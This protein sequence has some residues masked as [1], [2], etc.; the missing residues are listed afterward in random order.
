MRILR[1][2]S[3]LASTTYKCYECGWSSSCHWPTRLGVKR[4]PIPRPAWSMDRITPPAHSR[5]IPSSAS[6]ALAWRDPARGDGRRYPQQHPADGTQRH[7]RLRDEL[8]GAATVCLGWP[9][10]FPGARQPTRRGCED[11]GGPRRI[12]G[13]EVTVTLVM[14][15]PRYFRPPPA[16]PSPRTSII[17]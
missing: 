5:R 14:R 9:G 2:F 6:S 17:P 15:R 10:Q 16:T 7:P 1:D 12:N 11:P 3:R 4:L 8:P 13:P